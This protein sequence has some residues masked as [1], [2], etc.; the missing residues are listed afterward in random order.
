MDVFSNYVIEI[1][2]GISPVLQMVGISAF[3][4]AEGLPII[5]SIL[6]GGTVALLAG[7]LSATG[8]F[9]PYLAFIVIAVSSFFGDM[10][11]FFLGKKFKEKVW[12]KKIVNSEKHQ[13][14]WDLFD[15]HL[16]II[17]IFGKLIPVVRSTPSI[18]AAVRGVRTRRYMVYSFLGSFLWAFSGVFLGKILTEFLGKK[19]IPLIFGFLI[20]SVVIVL[21]RQIIKSKK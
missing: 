4:Y 6:P 8:V 20:L 2:T 10:T 1:L 19:A 21:L 16:A 17:S 15:R 13:K 18:F 11:G 5:G 3:S 9:S 12:I 7:S 14:S